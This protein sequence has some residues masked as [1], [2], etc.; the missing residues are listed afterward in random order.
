MC[1]RMTH[2]VMFKNEDLKALIGFAIFCQACH[3]IDK[4]RMHDLICKI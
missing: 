3:K 2:D 1:F 4:I